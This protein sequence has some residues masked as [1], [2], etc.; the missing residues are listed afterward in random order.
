MDANV[1][2]Y[3]GKSPSEVTA[4]DAVKLFR[5]V[6]R[7]RVGVVTDRIKWASKT[8]DVPRC[9]HC[10]QRHRL[11]EVSGNAFTYAGAAL[12]AIGGALFAGL[13]RS[14]PFSNIVEV[15]IGAGIGM[16]AGFIV[17]GLLGLLFARLVVGTTRPQSTNRECPPVQQCIAEGW[18]VGQPP[19]VA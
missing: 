10:K 12:G 19:D 2:W 14:R 18:R 7:T 4:V 11:A 15:L 1:C 17:L 8:V 3:C 6:T 13:S 16:V 5:D 9:V